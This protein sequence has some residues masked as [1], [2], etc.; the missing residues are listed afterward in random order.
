MVIDKSITIEGSGARA[1][2]IRGGGPV[3]T[4]GTFDAAVEPTVTIEGVTITGGV[5]AG[6]PFPGA[7]RRR[8]DGGGVFVPPGADGNGATVTISD[9]VIR[10]NRV[11]PAESAPGGP[12]CPGEPCQFASA[13]GGGIAAFGPLTI[14]KT[15]V[16][17]NRVGRA[18]GLPDASSEA[19][20]G[21]I[22][23]FGTLTVVDSTITD[24]RTAA[25]APNGRFAEGAGVWSTGTQTT[26]TGGKLSRNTAELSSALPQDVEQHALG[27]ALEVTNVDAT[28]TIDRVRIA[29]NRVAA[30]NTVGD[31]TA[32]GGG[33]HVF[34]T[35]VMRDSTVVG[36]RVVGTVPA[37]SPGNVNV[38]SGGIEID[39][40]ATVTGSRFED[41][42]I[43]ATGPNDVLAAGAGIALAPLAR[44]AATIHD[45][46]VRGNSLVAKAGS[47]SATVQGA[48]IQTVGLLTLSDVEIE[49]NTGAATGP[50]GVAQGGGIWNGTGTFDGAPPAPVLTLR[51][52]TIGRNALQAGA[53][54]AVNGGGLFTNARVTRDDTRIA[55]NTPDD[56]SGC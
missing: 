27:A 39:D 24:N 9:S 30:T 36:N 18:S 17:G 22:A 32:F 47:G 19:I 50:A 45:S 35:L 51:D 16:E 5:T 25:A 8:A 6:S 55:G 10:D 37:G 23:S 3:V 13:A 21:G 49:R 34:G 4:I 7:E 20:G 48:G 26:I 52:T 15:L 28:T 14:R 29:D 12:P 43:E 44:E 33:P 41:N 2:V 54:I 56:C 1:T 40:N 38:T 53:G 42:S 46:R 11:A 31:A